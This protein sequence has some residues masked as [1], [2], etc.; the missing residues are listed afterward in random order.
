MRNW[1]LIFRG[2]LVILT[3]SVSLFL[4]C[5]K[6]L[7]GEVEFFNLQKCSANRWRNKRSEMIYYFL[8]QIVSPIFST[9]FLWNQIKNQIISMRFWR[10]ETFKISNILHR[11][12]IKNH[13]ND[14]HFF[15]IK[16]ILVVSA[17]YWKKRK[18][19]TDYETSDLSRY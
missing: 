9:T 13:T 15:S 5:K 8:S 16:E 2:T 19:W 4:K 7:K 11:F 10:T 12:L 14:I 6:N 17:N 18:Y 1:L 3:M